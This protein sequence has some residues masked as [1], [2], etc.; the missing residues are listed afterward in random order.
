MSAPEPIA[1]LHS[2]SAAD[3]DDLERRREPRIPTR[4][5]ARLQSSRGDQEAAMLADVSLHGCCVNTSA[6][7][8][9]QGSFVSV[10]LGE[11]TPMLAAIVR[12]VRG[13]AAGMEFLRPIPSDRIEWLDL[14]DMPLA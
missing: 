13:G 9:R 7:W 2:K 1:R 8:L 14:I 11:E 4:Y 12:W 3:A 5:A 10:G 6:G